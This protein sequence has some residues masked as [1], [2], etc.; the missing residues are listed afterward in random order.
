MTS[1][2]DVGPATRLGHGISIIPLPLPFPSP[3]SV[4]AYVLE[5]DVG[6]ILID[7]GADWSPGWQT[8]MEGFATLLLEPADV[9]SLVVTHLHPDHVGM[10][11][12]VTEELSCQ[13]VMHASAATRYERYNDTPGLIERTRHLA[14]RHGVPPELVEAIADLGPRPDFMPLLKPPDSVVEDGERIVFDS[15]RDL[16]VLHTPGHE[17]SHICLT[18]SLTGILFSGDHVLPR[19]TPVIMFDEESDD[20]LGDY[21]QSLQR[22]VDRQIGL[23]YP[24]HGTL[25]ERGTQRATQIILHHER[26]LSGME[27]I[28]G[29]GPATGWRVMEEAY[30]P[31]LTPMEQRLALRETL[32]HLEYLRRRRQVSVFEEDGVVYYRSA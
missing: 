16:T 11:P 15:E 26:R 21:L 4:N 10:A 1:I 18:D 8:L 30:R 29:R 31:H 17:A 25:I 6:L 3:R 32:S 20:P 9:T 14:L 28:V 19:I 27:E 5:S 13:L 2:P 12:R 23:T 22:L 24:A 7:C